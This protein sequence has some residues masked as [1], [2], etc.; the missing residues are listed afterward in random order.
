[1]ERHSY[2]VCVRVRVRVRADGT[3]FLS[4]MLARLQ[5]YYYHDVYLWLYYKGQ[6]RMSIC[7]LA[8]LSLPLLLSNPNPNPTLTLTLSGLPSL[9]LHSLTITMRL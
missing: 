9:H 3:P 5:A 6:V 4:G 2:R 7:A 1:M 8:R